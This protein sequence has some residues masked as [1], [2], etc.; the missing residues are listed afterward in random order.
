MAHPVSELPEAP[1]PPALRFYARRWDKRRATASP[2]QLGEFKRALY[3]LEYGQLLPLMEDPELSWEVM[4]EKVGFKSEYASQSLCSIASQFFPTARKSRLRTPPRERRRRAQ[5]LE[6][7]FRAANPLFAELA[8]WCAKEGLEAG[9]SPVW[10]NYRTR[11]RQNAF[12]VGEVVCHAARHSS[13][14]STKNNAQR[15]YVRVVPTASLECVC[16]VRFVD[17]A[18][19]GWEHRAV[20][21]FPHDAWPGKDRRGELAIPVG[22]LARDWPYARTINYEAYRDERGRALLAKAIAAA[23]AAHKPHP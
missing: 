23:R 17:V 12:L 4:V 22:P 8:A 6:R 3:R 14:F 15:R 19:D 18:G 21:V 20:Y 7:E 9:V 5:E 10:N 13:T 1:V 11:I 2:A 16:S